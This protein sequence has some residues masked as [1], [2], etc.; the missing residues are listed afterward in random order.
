MGH[1][2]PGDTQIVQSFQA[3][4]GE[5]HSVA[6]WNRSGSPLLYLWGQSD[7]L[8]AFQFGSGTFNTTPVA[9]NSLPA[10]FPGGVLAVSANGSTAGSG[11]V[12]ATTPSSSSANAVVVGTLRAYDAS[13]VSNELWDSNQNAARDALGNFAKFTSP[14]IDNGK[15]YVPTFSNQLAV[16]GVIGSSTGVSIW[17]GPTSLTLPANGEPFQFSATVAGTSNTAVNWT[18]SP[19]LGTITSNGLY[20]P[21]YPGTISSSQTVTITATSLADTTKSATATVT[22]NPFVA[23]GTAAFVALDTATEGNWQGVYGSNGYNVINGTVAYPSY[24]TVTPSGANSRTWASSTTDVRALY[25]SATSTNRIAAAWYNPTTSFLIDLV[26]NDGQ[27]HQ[28]AIY[29]LDW[30]TTKRAETVAIQ[31]AN[32]VPLASTQNV[33]NFHNG[34]YLVYQLSGHVQI[35][36]TNISSGGNAVVSGLFFK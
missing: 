36:V 32:G 18:V 3:T 8:K 28:V 30:D 2:Q 22:L 10:N 9:E 23:T 25:T 14:T 1:Y 31:D 29:C 26:F 13:N 20:T 4:S 33:S 17:L 6:Y 21:P 24:V 15:V 19:S 35:R 11:I 12:W 27:Q 5:I 34:E 7:V 16:Y